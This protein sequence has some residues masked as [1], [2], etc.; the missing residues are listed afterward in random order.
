MK[1]NVTRLAFK[2]TVIYV[3]VAGCWIFFSDN[4]V[5]IFV[6]DPGERLLLSIYKGWLY[7]GLTGALLFQVLRR[8]MG[9]WEHAEQARLVTLEKLRESEERQRLVLQ[10]SAD[11]LWDWNV[12]TDSAYVSPRYGELVGEPAGDKPSGLKFLQGLVHPEDWPGLQQSIEGHLAGKTPQ[13]SDEFR[14]V[15]RTGEVK[16]I[17]GRGQLVSRTSEGAPLR[18][19]GTISDITSR[20][21]AEAALRES[22]ERYKA[23][24]D[25]S[26]DCVFLADF[27]GRFLDANQSALD[28]LGYRRE[29]IRSL[30]FASLLAAEEMGRAMEVMEEIK[31]NG[32]QK[33]LTELTLH[34]RDGREVFVEIQSSL[35]FRNGAP[36]AIQ[37]I[38][39]D[40]TARRR[41]EMDLARLA[42][43]VEQ[44]AETIVITNTQGE[45]LYANPAFEKISGYTCKEV[46]GRNPRFLKSGK[47]DA[48]FYRQMWATL[49]RG[50]I[51]TGHFI[52][53]RK[54]G[55]EY[56]EEATISPIRDAAGKV[57]NYVAVKRDV[58]HEMQLESQIRQ[59]QKMEA[60]GTLAGGIAHDFNN[61]LTAIFG[62]AHLLQM[63]VADQPQTLE[64]TREIIKSA[65][66]AS[67]L[68]RQILTFSRRR[69]QNREVIRLDTIV[70]EAAKFLRA[71]LP[72][73][74]KVETSIATDTPTVLA[75][76]TQI[77]Q[78][79]MNLGTNAF[80]AMEG[81]AG[82]LTI[83]LDRFAPDMNDLAAN[84]EL[85]SRDYARL[86][87]ADTGH[88]MDAKTLERIFEPFFTTKPVGKGT[89]LGLA[90][91]H[92]IVRSHEG[93]ITVASQAG[94]G[95]KFT[96]YFPA[97]TDGAAPLT[98]PGEEL[99]GGNRQRILLVD[100]E[101]ALTAVFERMLKRLN[102]E[103]TVTNNPQEAIALFQKEPGHY[104][105]L[106]T[107]LTMPQMD[108]LNLARQVHDIRPELPIML[109]SGYCALTTEN[110]RAAGICELVEKPVSLAAIAEAIHRVMNRN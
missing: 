86:V 34:H 61:I 10:A 70:K 83:S 91:V 11:G 27:E 52:N 85:R 102:Y 98:S 53:R 105:L 110:L 101:V 69:E 82:T 45:I 31:K 40:I 22:E 36:A 15:T 95:T 62:N 109:V 14:I 13:C 99:V 33:Q 39:R 24:F 64:N 28:L 30:T 73:L 96:L 49:E 108:G 103:V 80:H 26:L 42:K 81:Q 35:I 25:R 87:I 66:R 41:A 94:Q 59:S 76:S 18:M 8:W 16:W 7:V 48:E 37:G 32:F 71:S 1:N 65:E 47:H 4:I 77:Y 44:A 56:Q 106:I 75:D 54:D 43:A 63:D 90:V 74:I 12:K 29:D 67:D 84:G 20:K 88:G 3:I 2:V 107:D 58:T 5:A 93:V 9:Q 100:D 46:I 89:G 72:A 55:T 6:R 68:V 50:K 104:H 92:G 57:I 79:I 78:V 21:L 51:W 17:L 23:L 60:I 97:Q 38:A 19:V